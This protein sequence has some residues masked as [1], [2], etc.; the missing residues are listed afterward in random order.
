MLKDEFLNKLLNSCQLLE[1][2]EEYF[3]ELDSKFGDGD[4]GITIT[5]I[6]KC[7]ENTVRENKEKTLNDIF[8]LISNN[9]LNMGAGSASS[10]WGM[11]FKGFSEAGDDEFGNEMIKNMFVKAYENLRIITKAEIGDK[12]LMDAFLPGYNKA[13]ENS[14]FDVIV[15]AMNKG[16]LDTSL[17]AAKF[18][19]AKNYQEE[20]IG[21]LDPGAVSLAMFFK[22]LI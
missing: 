8:S 10:L 20:S 6:A 7:I 11:L 15:D 22:G 12:T 1:S 5:K 2:N 4:H 16:A 9:I 18:G 14:E 21:S 19:R 3:G 13:L 17:Y